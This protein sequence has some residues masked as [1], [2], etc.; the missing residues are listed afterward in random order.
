MSHYG[1]R[2]GGLSNSIGYTIKGLLINVA[3]SLHHDL[4][5]EFKMSMKFRARELK[6]VQELHETFDR[7][8]YDAGSEKVL[9]RRCQP[10][11]IRLKESVIHE[12]AS[13]TD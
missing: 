6:L 12:L 13:Q 8:Q 1:E 5:D 7:D 4:D 2:L 11:D 3:K 9:L 10:R